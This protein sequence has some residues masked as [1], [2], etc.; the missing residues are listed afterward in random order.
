MIV[1]TGGAGFIGSNLVQ[2][3][4][5][6]G[7]D[8]IVVVDDLNDPRK[9]DN[10]SDLR[11]AEC[12]EKRKF[13]DALENGGHFGAVTAVFHQGACSDTMCTDGNYVLFN[14]Y[15]YS[16][17]LFRHCMEHRIPF[18]YASSASVY[19]RGNR[20]REAP[21]NE[22][23]LNAYGWSK[24]MFDNYVRRQTDLPVQCAGLRYFNVYGPRESH[25]D[26]MASVAWHFYHQYRESGTVKLFA[27]TGGFADG[28]QVRDFIYVDDIVQ[29]NLFLLDRPDLSGIFNVGTGQCQSF[30]EVAL[31]VINSCR[32]TDGQDRISL[33]K[34]R[35]RGEIVYV[36]LPGNLEGKYQSYTRA[37]M[38]RL[39]S[40]GYTAPFDN[41]ATGVSKYLSILESSSAQPRPH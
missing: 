6:M 35:A 37:D 4:N 30:N 8:R 29:V 9:A 14:N 36:P 17:M 33:E 27:G 39:T 20:F 2:A 10:L 31:S 18:I 22:S 41:V 13:L 7:Y 16:K 38:H 40:S 11:V 21:E 23:A 15:L 26:T 1:V 25:K 12:L 28:E 3:L 34:A 24:L 19:G 32:E 5:R